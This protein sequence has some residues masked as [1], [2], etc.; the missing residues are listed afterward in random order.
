M[1]DDLLELLSDYYFYIAGDLLIEMGIPEF[2]IRDRVVGKVRSVFDAAES[3]I[4]NQDNE[5]Y[6]RF[7]NITSNS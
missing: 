7:K 1:N 5:Y 6:R 2:G 3:L 4:P